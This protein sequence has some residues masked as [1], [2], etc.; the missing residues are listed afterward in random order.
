MSIL[1][2]VEELPY[3]IGC[4]IEALLNEKGEDASVSCT[5]DPVMVEEPDD[6]KDW[7]KA[8]Q[9]S[10]LSSGDWVFANRN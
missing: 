3:R 9:G 4:E 10:F 5:E 8:N 7:P 1:R 6:V 2:L